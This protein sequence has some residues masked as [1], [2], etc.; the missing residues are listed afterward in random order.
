M[1]NPPSGSAKGLPSRERK[2]NYSLNLPSPNRPCQ[3]EGYERS[4]EPTPTTHKT[5]GRFECTQLLMGKKKNK[6]IK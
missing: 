4:L 2:K 1:N 6:H 5:D 3:G